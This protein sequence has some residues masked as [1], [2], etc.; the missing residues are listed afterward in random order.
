[1]SSSSGEISNEIQ[2]QEPESH[3]ISIQADS[4]PK[5]RI[6]MFDGVCNVCHFFVNFVFPRDVNKQFH[7]QA[8]QTKKGRE[9][10]EQWGVPQDLST[11]VLVDEFE[12]R[13]YTKSTAIFRILSG[14]SGGWS[15]LYYAIYMP[16]FLRDA[17]YTA[18]G[19][20]RYYVFGKKD[21]CPF[22]P[23]LK[24]RFVDWK[25]PIVEDEPNDSKAM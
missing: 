11:V 21:E 4:R 9:I 20:V 14:L 10:C 3:A 8:L 17:G 16:Q 25:S 2:T 6:I 23:T 18:F 12:G 1:M 24:D 19:S 15:Y 13:Y 7:F 5:R 22:Y